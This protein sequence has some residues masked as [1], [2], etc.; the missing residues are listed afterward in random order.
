MVSSF[1][2]LKPRNPTIRF[3]EDT[4]RVAAPPARALDGSLARETVVLV[5][6]GVSTPI[7]VE[8]QARP[9]GGCQGYW[10]CP[11]CDRRC[12]ALFIVQNA[13]ACRRCLHLGYRS[14]SRQHHA[15]VLRVAKLRKKLGAGPSLLSKLPPR[16]K[17]NGQAA[18]YDRL[19]RELAEQE[20]IVAGMLGGIVHALKRRKGRL[21]G[22]R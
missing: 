8:R 7:E 17:H 9:R 10:R 2:A 14:R 15:A 12:C 1:G 13:P 19:V 6:G 18:R 5:I 21:H 16:P 22:P 11:H 3:V 4:Q 20:A